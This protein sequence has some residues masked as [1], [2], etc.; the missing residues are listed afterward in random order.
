MKSLQVLIVTTSHKSL[1]DRSPDTGLWLQELAGPYY[2]FKDAGEC[3]TITSPLGGPVPIDAKSESRDVITESITRF[4]MD[5]QA[6]FQ[7]AHSLPL[8][9]VKAEHFDLIFITGGHG[10]M[11]DLANNKILKNLLEAFNSMGKPIGAVGSGVVGIVALQNVDGTPFVK[12]KKLTA[13]SN[14]EVQLEGLTY[15]V[16]FLLESQ[17]LSLGAFYSRSPDYKSHVV[18]DG[19]LVT[20]QNPASSVDTAKAVKSIACNAIIPQK[21]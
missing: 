20:G 2:V 21:V 15:L 19:N 5:E 3:I 1:G 9:E 4:K 14:A 13:Y 10:A 12:D 8:N 7:L 16:P 17:L 18:T 11:L 6:L